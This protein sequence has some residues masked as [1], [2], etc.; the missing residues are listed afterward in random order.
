MLLEKLAEEYGPAKSISGGHFIENGILDFSPLLEA[1]AEMDDQAYG[2][3]LFHYTIV[4]GLKSWV[5]AENAEQV[6]FSGGCFMN[7]IL[8]RELRKGLENQGI[9]VF[10]AQGFTPND[11][12]IS[13]GPAYAAMLGKMSCA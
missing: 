8:C 6:V 1:L 9:S 5:F 10:E 4:E 11:G 12:G 2:V 7:G 3:S 13:L